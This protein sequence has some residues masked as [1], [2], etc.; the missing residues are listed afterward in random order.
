MPAETASMTK[1]ANKIVADAQD[2]K[3]RAESI[4]ADA[5]K[6]AEAI[7]RDGVETLRAQTRAYADTAAERLDD[8]QRVVID[9]VRERP[10]QSTMVAFGVGVFLGLLLARRN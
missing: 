7:V 3:E 4:L 9:R 6:R 2:A 1:N 5:A 10:L 8:A